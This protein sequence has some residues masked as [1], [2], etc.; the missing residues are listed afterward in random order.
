MC[1]FFVSPKK[2]LIVVLSGL[3]PRFFRDG[4]FAYIF[5]A[6][7]IIFFLHFRIRLGAEYRFHVASC[8]LDLS[9][10]WCKVKSSVSP[11][12]LLLVFFH[13]LSSSLLVTLPGRLD[14]LIA[15]H[16]SEASGTHRAYSRFFC[17]VLMTFM[18]AFFFTKCPGGTQ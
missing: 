13:N 17:L 1:T 16:F 6:V 12:K 10:L 8:N 18:C 14:L 11:H 4:D 9:R 2:I 5:R 15:Q 3:R 7:N